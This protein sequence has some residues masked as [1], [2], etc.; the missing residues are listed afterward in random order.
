MKTTTKFAIENKRPAIPNT[1]QTMGV[2]ALIKSCWDVDF[3]NRPPFDIIVQNCIQ[4]LGSTPSIQELTP[5]VRVIS[6][7]EEFHHHAPSPDIRPTSSPMAVPPITLNRSTSSP[8]SGGTVT[9]ITPPPREGS[10]LRGLGLT[11]I[12]ESSEGGSSSYQTAAT[13]GS[14]S[15]HSA[16][17]ELNPNPNPNSLAN[18]GDLD[19]SRTPRAHALDLEEWGARSVSVNHPLSA[20]ASTMFSSTG[21]TRE[22]EIITFLEGYES[23][24]PMDE[25]IALRRD[26]R[27]YRFLLNPP[28]YASRKLFLFLCRILV[29]L[30]DLSLVKL[31]LWTPSAVRVGALGYHSKPTGE[32]ITLFNAF[33]PPMDVRSKED[34]IASLHAYGSIA[35]SSV[36]KDTRSAGERAIEGIRSLIPFPRRLEGSTSYVHCLLLSL[37]SRAVVDDERIDGENL[38]L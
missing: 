4:L 27:R 12:T 24:P 25:L 26:E 32:F 6:I 3:K 18:S 9:G 36:R 23:P 17:A 31:P 1:I 15:S 11:G 30:T 22:S 16:P 14:H 2:T 5:P 20:R 28:L 37:L 19:P 10:P 34:M 13:F 29:I 8:I 35:T 21:S 7:N 38:G 33:E